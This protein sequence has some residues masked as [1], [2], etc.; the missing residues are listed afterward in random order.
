MVDTVEH[1][2]DSGDY[3]VELVPLEPSL[4]LKHIELCLDP[5]TIV[6][7]QYKV[8]SSKD[9]TP[10]VTPTTKYSPFCSSASL[11]AHPD[12]FAFSS[13]NCSTIW[14]SWS[15]SASCSTST[16]VI[17]NNNTSAMQQENHRYA[18]P[19]LCSE[20]LLNYSDFRSSCS[21]TLVSHS[22]MVASCSDLPR[23]CSDVVA[24]CS[25]RTPFWYSSSR[26]LDSARSRSRWPSGCSSP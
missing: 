18:I 13:R 24:S 8:P 7:R 14:R 16:T 21:N 10:P 12:S 2:F 20:T 5:P 25:D 26:A 23:N 19:F 9:I 11:S 6:C 15:S 3:G 22:E 4:L 1:R 17:S